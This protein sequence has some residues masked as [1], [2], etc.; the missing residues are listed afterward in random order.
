MEPKVSRDVLVSAIAVWTRLQRWG[1]V[2]NYLATL[3]SPYMLRES[4]NATDQDPYSLRLARRVGEVVERLEK[5]KEKC[6]ELGVTPRGK[7]LALADV[8]R[9]CLC[10]TD[11]LRSSPVQGAAF[12]FKTPASFLLSQPTAD[13]AVAVESR[14]VSGAM[15]MEGLHILTC[16]GVQLRLEV[17]I[18]QLRQ[19]IG[20][21]ITGVHNLTIVHSPEELQALRATTMLLEDL[22]SIYNGIL[23]IFPCVR[24]MGSVH[25]PNALLP[26]ILKLYYQLSEWVIDAQNTRESNV[27]PCVNSFSKRKLLIKMRRGDPSMPWGI[28]F[29][30]E[31]KLARISPSVRSGSP[32][33]ESVHNL[34][35]ST[36]GGLSIVEINSEGVEFANLTAKQAADKLRDLTAS[37]LRLNIRLGEDLGQAPSLEQIAFFTVPDAMRQRAAERHMEMPRATLVL[38]RDFCGIPWDIGISTDLRV[39]DVP[40]TILSREA[41]TFFKTH[42]RQLRIGAINGVQVVNVSQV[43]A[44]SMFVNTVVL[45]FYDV[46]APEPLVLEDQKQ[47]PRKHPKENKTINKATRQRALPPHEPLKCPTKFHEKEIER[48]QGSASG[49]SLKRYDDFSRKDR[50]SSVNAAREVPLL[51]T[52]T[53]AERIM[54][55]IRMTESSQTGGGTAIGDR[56]KRGMLSKSEGLQP[57]LAPSPILKPP[58]SEVSA[59]TAGGSGIGSTTTASAD[60]GAALDNTDVMPLSFPNDVTIDVFTTEEMV[61]RRPC[62]TKKWGFLLLAEGIDS[63]KK[64]LMSGL[65][66]MLSIQEQ[67]PFSKLFFSRKGQWRIASINGTPASQLPEVIDVMKHALRMQIKF[68]RPR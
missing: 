28:Q 50:S 52:P 21:E 22:E 9:F 57:A 17:C 54:A 51:S 25:V 2:N 13:W 4:H 61:V 58:A 3:N 23:S 26:I 20:E 48:P 11:S 36:K 68:F 19:H 6:M 38:H 15:V 46:P 49:T 33:A 55:T 29:S 62:S 7:L 32:A 66:R 27:F 24:V 30:D 12:P 16:P 42:T 5:Q 63:K 44:L 18:A 14:G 53:V 56:T 60:A 35:Q 8:V 10:S 34:A 31:G 59:R 45:D 65:P 39:V 67:H 41:G 47:K 37:Q 1:D 40:S 64:I 43:E